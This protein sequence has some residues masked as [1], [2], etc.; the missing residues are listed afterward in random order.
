VGY[1]GYYL[2]WLALSYAIRQPW[3]LGGLVVLWL[4]RSWVPTPGA[5]FGAMSRAGRLREQVRLNKANI[6]ARRDLATIYIDVLRPRKALP[7]LEEGLTLAPDDAELLFLYGLALHRAGRHEDALSRLLLALE[8]DSRL[9]HGMP[10]FVAGQALLGLKRWDDAADAFERYLDFNSSDVAAHT[11]LARAYAGGKDEAGAQKWLLAG[12][13]TWHAL[14]GSLKRRQFGAYLKGQWARV[15][16]LKQPLAIALF[17]LL[18]GLGAVLARASYPLVASLWGPSR[19]ERV[20][21]RAREAAKQCGKHD[22]GEFAGRYEWSMAEAPD[23][24]NQIVIDKDRI[25]FATD[26]EGEEGGQWCLTRVVS[27]AAGSLHAEAMMQLGPNGN[28]E[29]LDALEDPSVVA[30]LLYDVRLDRGA[31]VTRL[32]MAPVTEPLSAT[33]YDLHPVTSE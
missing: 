25:R 32:R 14:P 11:H 28:A 15:A 31:K 9:R 3:L 21:A 20:L 19:N 27:R 4:L 33:A 6:T 26:E 12:L 17:V 22:T 18:L 5:L 7:L 24:K 10:Y 16:V 13:E 2:A 29:L 1:F 30:G 8:K 23:Q